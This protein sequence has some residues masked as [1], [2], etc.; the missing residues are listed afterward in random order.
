M[1]LNALGP[2]RFF[3]NVTLSLPVDTSW[4]KDYGVNMYIKR[5]KIFV[6]TACNQ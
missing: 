3:S 2:T 6:V 4:H 1:P 5:D